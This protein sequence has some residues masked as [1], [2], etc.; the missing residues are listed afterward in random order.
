MKGAGPTC[1][2]MAFVPGGQAGKKREKS[3]IIGRGF[4]D[5]LQT[6]RYLS[7]SPFQT[8]DTLVRIQ[9]LVSLNGE[10]GKT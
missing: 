9:R 5:I 4:P 3:I 8:S 6:Y 7:P 10:L 1:R 2:G